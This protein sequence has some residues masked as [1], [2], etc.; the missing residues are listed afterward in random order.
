MVDGVHIFYILTILCILFLLNTENTEISIS[1]S[2]FLL[3]KL[4][5]FISRI[6]KL[7]YRVKNTHLGFLH[8]LDKWI[9][10]I[11]CSF[12]LLTILALKYILLDYHCSHRS[13][14]SVSFNTVYLFPLFLLTKFIFKV[15]TC[16][17]HTVGSSCL[18][19]SDNFY[20]LMV[21]L[22]HLYLI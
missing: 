14:L 16:M 2:L 5:I 15:T 6:L 7:C 19:Q 3:L 11:R 1:V 13:F 10:I 18:I 20:I 17:K 12:S 4:S 22:N 8:L 21:G 9:L